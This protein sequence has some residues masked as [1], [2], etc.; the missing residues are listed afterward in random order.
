MHIPATLAT[1][2]LLLACDL[3]LRFSLPHCSS[4]VQ[5]GVLGVL[6]APVLLF[7]LFSALRLQFV[8]PLLDTL[9]LWA[10]LNGY[11]FLVVSLTRLR[12]RLLSAGVACILLAP[13]LSA[14]LLLPLTA[15]FDTHPP[16]TVWLD[17]RYV[18]ERYAVDRGG[19]GS[20]AAD[21]KIF[22][23]S[24]WLPTLQRH[25]VTARFVQTQ[26]DAAH[27]FAELLPDRSRVLLHCPALPGLPAASAVVE[28]HS[29]LSGR[30]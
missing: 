12:P 24:P 3:A 10:S 11:L 14:S 19:Y 13:L 9:L 28:Q 30:K 22:R 21:L 2:L 25:I 20:N 6:Y 5:R 1:I 17:S 15:L 18:S 16:V 8:S 29:L 23:R 7:G 26:C 27:S 4:S